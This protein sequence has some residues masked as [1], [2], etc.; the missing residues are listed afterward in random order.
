M[1]TAIDVLQYWYEIATVVIAV[2]A[3]IA[4][5]KII[6]NYGRHLNLVHEAIVG[7]PEVPGLVDPIPSM[8]DRFHKVDA[9]L[10]SQ[11]VRL[12]VIESEHFPNGGS[13]MRDSIN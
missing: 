4:L 1:I 6:L 9:H 8:I 11:D 12:E 7:R 13:S 3:A 2:P 10:T 5:V